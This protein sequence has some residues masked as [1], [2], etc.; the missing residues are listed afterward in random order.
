VFVYSPS[1]SLVL[2]SSIMLSLKKEISHVINMAPRPPTFYAQL[3]ST[4][5]IIGSSIPLN[6]KK[7]TQQSKNYKKYISM[8]ILINFILFL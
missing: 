6:F 7:E 1:L 4:L 3:G 2:Y 5:D 8:K